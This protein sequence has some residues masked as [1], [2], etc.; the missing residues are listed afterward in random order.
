[1]QMLIAVLL[2]TLH[3]TTFAFFA[4]DTGILPKSVQLVDSGDLAWIADFN[5]IEPKCAVQMHFWV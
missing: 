1:M 2:S 3:F 4:Y 5:L